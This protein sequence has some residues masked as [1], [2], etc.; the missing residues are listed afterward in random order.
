[1]HEYNY[2]IV[3]FAELL[4]A[5]Y[6]S[7]KTVGLWMLLKPAVNFVR[8]EKLG[9]LSVR[10]GNGRLEGQEVG[11]VISN[12][13]VVAGNAGN[14]RFF[15]VDGVIGFPRFRVVQML[16]EAEQE[17]AFVLHEAEGEKAVVL[18]QVAAVAHIP[19]VT[20]EVQVGALARSRYRWCR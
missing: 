5:F 20:S 17:D 12:A 4:E 13:L 16:A 3:F 6:F 15:V 7:W 9:K 1:M 10:I 14:A 11:Q 19:A 18:V 2:R 8:L